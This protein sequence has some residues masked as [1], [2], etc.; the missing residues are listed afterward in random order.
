MPAGDL[1]FSRCRHSGKLAFPPRPT[2]PSTPTCSSSKKSVVAAWAPAFINLLRLLPRHPAVPAVPG[3]PRP[4]SLA[5]AAAD[6]DAAEFAEGKAQGEGESGGEGAA[7][8]AGGLGPRGRIL[9]FVVFVLLSLGAL[10]VALP[11]LHAAQLR[12]RA[13]SGKLW[14]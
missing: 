10:Q 11:R 13:G 12:R 1:S 7:L 5:A 2:L 14:V 4:V 9:V 6:H 3:L 8:A